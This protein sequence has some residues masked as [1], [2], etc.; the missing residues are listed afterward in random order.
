MELLDHV[1]FYLHMVLS[2]EFLREIDV[3]FFYRIFEIFLSIPL[4]KTLVDEKFEVLRNREGIEF[5]R[6]KRNRGVR[7]IQPLEDVFLDVYVI[8][9]LACDAFPVDLLFFTVV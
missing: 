2:H 5:H 9:Q 6:E 3:H 7:E 4:E 8:V 1:L